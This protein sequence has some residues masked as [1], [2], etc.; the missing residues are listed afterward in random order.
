VAG[1]AALIAE[2]EQSVRQRHYSHREAEVA[3]AQVELLLRQGNLATA[4]SLAETH[5]LTLSRARVHLAQDEP[6]A[7]QRLLE[8]WRQQVDA[9]GWQDERLKVRVLQ[10]IACQAVGEKDQALQRLGEALALAQPGDLIRAFVDEGAPLKAVLQAAV[11]R[12]LAPAYTR[13]LLAAFSPAESGPVGAADTPPAG[14]TAPAV[15]L[16]A[17]SARELEVLRLVAQGLSNAEIAQ[18]LYLALNTIKGHNLRL[19]AKLQV[20]NRTE[21]VARA[22]ELGLL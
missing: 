21:A 5:R 16:E 17:L 18:R 12:G 1:A 19:F 13:R 10:A 22:R 8:P 2:A 3:A 7:A 6:A 9:R 11:A 15:P 4:A 20:Q 14:R